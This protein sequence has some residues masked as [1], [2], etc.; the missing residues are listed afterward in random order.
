MFNLTAEIVSQQFRSRYPALWNFPASFFFQVRAMVS[1]QFSQEA[2]EAE[3]KKGFAPKEIADSEKAISRWQFKHEID[4]GHAVKV[5]CALSRMMTAS[6][7]TG[8]ITPHQINNW[9]AKEKVDVKTSFKVWVVPR[10]APQLRSLPEGAFVDPQTVNLPAGISLE[11]KV[12]LY[13]NMPASELPFELETLS[14]EPNQSFNSGIEAAPT[15]SLMND[16]PPAVNASAALPTLAASMPSSL[17][18]SAAN[19]VVGSTANSVGG[20]RANA[21]GSLASVQLGILAMMEMHP[22]GILTMMETHL[23]GSCTMMTH[24][25]GM[26]VGYD[27]VLLVSCFCDRQK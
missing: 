27:G 19:S 17:V 9:I 15:I 26:F 25:L 3:I 7:K 13:N 16:A 14:L 5:H 23:L 11:G 10:N 12:L 21:Q 18:G 22:V 4:Q 1:R 6:G 24:L 20:S 2:V 8:R